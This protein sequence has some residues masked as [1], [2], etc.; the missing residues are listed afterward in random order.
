M[1]IGNLE[2]SSISYTTGNV[3]ALTGDFVEISFYDKDGFSNFTEVKTVNGDGSFDVVQSAQVEIPKASAGLVAQIREI[4]KPYA[5]LHVVAYTTAGVAHLLGVNFGCTAS[6]DI[7]SGTGRGDKNRVQLTFAGSENSLGPI[8]T[9]GC[10]DTFSV[11][12]GN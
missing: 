3:S 7:A 11:A 2:N 5:E 8:L 12:Y 1:F 10:W 9:Q 6:A 4:C